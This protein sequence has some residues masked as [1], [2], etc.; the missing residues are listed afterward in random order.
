MQNIYHEDWD[1]LGSFEVHFNSQRAPEYL[2]LEILEDV[3]FWY[4]KVTLTPLLYSIFIRT[5]LSVRHLFKV[6][7]I[8]VVVGVQEFAVLF[9]AVIAIC[10]S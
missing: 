3:G 9:L 4:L 1:R 10:H 6:V 5:S 8:Q 2:G 7:I